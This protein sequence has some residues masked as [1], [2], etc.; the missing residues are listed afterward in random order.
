MISERIKKIF[1]VAIIMLITLLFGLKC[2]LAT[3][4]SISDEL[5]YIATALRFFKGDAMLADDWTSVQMNGFLLMPFVG[6]YYSIFGSTEGIALCFRLLYLLMKLLVAF[7]VTFKLCKLGYRKIYTLMGV[8]FYYFFTPYN[9]DTLSYNTI[10]LTMILLIVVIILTNE[11]RNAEWFLAGVFLAIAILSHPFILLVY[12]FLS[13]FII[14]NRLTC[15]KM[16]DIKQYE[17]MWIY[18]TLG[19]I[20]V[21]TIFSVYIFSRASL[22][23]ILNN[24]PY[25]LQEPDHNSDF[26]D[27]V[28]NLI[29]DFFVQYKLITI[30][31]VGTILF[32]FFTRKKDYFKLMVLV[33]LA[34]SI[35][36][37]LCMRDPFIENLIFIPF[38]WFALEQIIMSGFDKKHILAYMVVLMYSFGV[39]LGTNTKMLSTSATMSNFAILSCFII[40]KMEND[41]EKHNLLEKVTIILLVTTLS[42]TFIFR[43][44]IVWMS[45]YKA[46]NFQK[47]IDVGPLKGMYAIEE[48]WNEY[49]T[50]IHDFDSVSFNAGEVLFCG[51]STPLAYLYSDLEYGTMGV[52]FF[53]LDY[54]RINDYWKMHLDKEPDIIYYLDMLHTDRENDFIENLN[55]NYKV[56]IIE[57]R[58]IAIKK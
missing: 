36:Y 54:D 17:K 37:L 32:F 9:I 50:V 19:S 51:T 44:F 53:F 2:L 48:V 34:V 14:I 39:Y 27:K 49:Y 7:V 43:L 21:A 10:P 4:I 45:W 15:K 31:N 18:I 55:K 12:L 25:I 40:A 16:K 13:L 8:A 56:K 5:S 58:L 57:N 52:S 46:E 28:R 6:I 11:N 3:E 30:V 41:V 22:S 20:C 42:M 1:G 47:Y 23:E 29:Y 26:F 33:S 24:L 35:L 38:M